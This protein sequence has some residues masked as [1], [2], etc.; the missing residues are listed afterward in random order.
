MAGNWQIAKYIYTVVPPYFVISWD[1]ET[2]DELWSEDLGGGDLLKKHDIM[3][4]MGPTNC[5]EIGGGGRIR[6]GLIIQIFQILT[7][8]IY[9]CFDFRIRIIVPKLTIMARCNHIIF[10]LNA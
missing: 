10:E 4:Q 7:I 1:R 9:S 2:S 6:G 8:G 3:D 5:D